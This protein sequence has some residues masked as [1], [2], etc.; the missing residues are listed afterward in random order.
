MKSLARPALLLAPG[1]AG[2]EVRQAGA[3]DQLKVFG[4]DS[5]VGASPGHPAVTRALAGVAGL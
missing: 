2:A 5:Q 1:M 3:A 4:V